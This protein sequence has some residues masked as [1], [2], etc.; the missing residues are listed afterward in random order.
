MTLNRL[1]EVDPHPEKFPANQKVPT[2]QPQ[3]DVGLWR[4][5]QKQEASSASCVAATAGCQPLAAIPKTRGVTEV[6][7]QQED[8]TLS[9]LIMHHWRRLVLRRVFVEPEDLFVPKPPAFIIHD[10][11]RFASLIVWK[12]WK[13]LH[14]EPKDS[15]DG[16][17]P[18]FKEGRSS[19]STQPPLT[20][21]RSRPSTQPPLAV[22]RWYPVS[23]QWRQDHAKKT[24]ARRG[25]RREGGSSSSPQLAVGRCRRW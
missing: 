2:C 9:D 3:P 14:V 10:W 25:K 20:E 22:G 23:Q 4:Q 24:A 16:Q 19:S 21:G 17:T 11:G 8:S 15:E 5:F 12:F 7:S 13:S 18:E 6:F 1:R